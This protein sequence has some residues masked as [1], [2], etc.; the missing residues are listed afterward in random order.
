MF[1]IYWLWMSSRIVHKWPWELTLSRLDKKLAPRGRASAK[2]QL[3]IRPR[4]P[5][6]WLPKSPTPRSSGAGQLVFSTGAINITLPSSLFASHW[7]AH[8]PGPDMTPCGDGG[9][10]STYLV[11]S[12]WSVCCS[13]PRPA[14]PV[15]YLK[16]CH[17]VGFIRSP[18]TWEVVPVKEPTLRSPG[19]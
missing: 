1:S 8:H 15:S 19:T 14:E 4:A 2:I 17:M 7:Q 13:A 5:F 16:L 3:R 18:E 11:S 10:W 6:F 12:Y 9:Q